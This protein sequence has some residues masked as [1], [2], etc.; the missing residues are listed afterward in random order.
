LSSEKKATTFVSFHSNSD[1]VFAGI[2]VKDTTKISQGGVYFS[3]DFGQTWQSKNTGLV[4][5]RTT[6]IYSSNTD[7]LYA[8]TLGA[9]LFRY[10]SAT[11]SWSALGSFDDSV[12]CVKVDPTNDSILIAGTYS[13][14]LFRSEDKGV[15]WVQLQKSPQLS[16][17]EIP[18][19]CWDI[20]FDPQNT[21]VIYTKL[22]SGQEIPWYNEGCT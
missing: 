5:T 15:T 7:D 3:N 16:N 9:G 19:V 18:A 1:Y 6:R 2:G 8:C 13:H 22:Y 12:T 20:E 11:Q 14:W 17:G 21:Q 4:L 10:N